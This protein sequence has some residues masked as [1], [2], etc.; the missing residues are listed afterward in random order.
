VVTKLYV[1]AGLAK[2][3][4]TFLQDVVFPETSFCY[5]GKN[6]EVSRK[7]FRNHP[8]ALFK[9]LQHAEPG[10]P[11]SE[12]KIPSQLI[13]HLEYYRSIASERDKLLIS[14]ELITAN[15]LFAYMGSLLRNCSH[16]IE[17]TN[18]PEECFHYGISHAEHLIYSSGQNALSA[19]RELSS[20]NTANQKIQRLLDA[21]GAELGGVLLV[22]RDFGS[23]FTS[24]FLQ[25]IKE[26]DEYPDSFLGNFMPELVF[27]FAGFAF[28]WDFYMRDFNDSG[29]ALASSFSASI[30]RKFGK[31]LVNI[32]EYSSSPLV[33]SENLKKPLESYGISNFSCD[34]IRQIDLDKNITKPCA[35]NDRF[36]RQVYDSRRQIS[37]DLNALLGTLGG[38]KVL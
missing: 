20:R 25:Y 14:D 10:V 15:P 4:T 24:L 29:F 3:G 34:K 35:S 27:A 33:F 12:L 5:L 21:F 8:F 19:R 38:L 32:A 2:T 30:Q 16:L 11:F 28:R 1:H 18:D 17:N 7:G 9:Y 13:K 36:E 23:W 6:S 22:K 37:R 31:N 26:N